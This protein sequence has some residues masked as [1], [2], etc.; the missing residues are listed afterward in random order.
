M[1][2][3]LSVRDLTVTFPVAGARHRL[4]AVD[5]VTLT[6]R[7]GETHGLV[8]E[9]G[10]GKSTLAR[11]IVGLTVP[12]VGEV[13]IG[14]QTL[15]RRRS[16]DE[17]RRVQMVFQDPISALN[18]R[19][20]VRDVLTELL[21]VHRMVPRSAVEERC[22]ELVAAVGL[23]ADV[24]DAWPGSLSGGQRQRVS[25]ARALALEPE[26]LIADEV[27]SALDVSVQ[28]QVLRLLLDL[29]A[30]L[31]LTVLFISH[32][33]AVVRQICDRVTVMYLGRIVET[34]PTEALYSD[35]QHPYTRLLLESVPRLDRVELPAAADTE[36]PDAAHL[37]GGC[38]FHP[39]CPLAAQ[40]CLDSDP[41]LRDGP[42]DR[43]AACHF[44]W[45]QR[46]EEG[47]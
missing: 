1:T 46:T 12:D 44:A 9:S 4:T 21:R 24:L 11:S 40:V 39:R 30:R 26:I 19:L 37:P 36:A 29:Q 23:P 10:C 42:P 5:A 27:T 22:R 18:P 31:G 32:N 47:T 7:P 3:G 13:A 33:L 16:H 43:A 20:R 6:V 41:V 45:P 35:P 38:R 8:G 28:A 15:P 25:I 34:G 14:D 17:Q 2:S